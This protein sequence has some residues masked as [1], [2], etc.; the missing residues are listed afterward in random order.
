MTMMELTAVRVQ[1]IRRL[2]QRYRRKYA[3]GL[4]ALLSAGCLALSAVILTLLR[5]IQT[6][7]GLSNPAS[8]YGAVLLRSSAGGYIVVCIAAFAAGTMAVILWIRF[9]QRQ[10][11]EEKP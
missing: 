7:I 9:Q 10:K 4:L 11:R 5:T 3:N 1:R 8:A 2:L 6:P